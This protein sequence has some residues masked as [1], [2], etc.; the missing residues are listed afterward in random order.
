VTLEGKLATKRLD[1][2]GSIAF[3]TQEDKPLY[4]AYLGVSSVLAPTL[5]LVSYM[6]LIENNG[7]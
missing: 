7:S 1:V 6:E 3:E 2:W 5:T 4:D